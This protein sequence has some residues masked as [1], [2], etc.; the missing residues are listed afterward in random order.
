MYLFII[1]LLLSYLNCNY[2]SN[3]IIN[4]LMNGMINVL[5]HNLKP[6]FTKKK[7]NQILIP[8]TQ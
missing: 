6:F 7:K 1:G 3:F 8:I 4:V 2:D 5:V